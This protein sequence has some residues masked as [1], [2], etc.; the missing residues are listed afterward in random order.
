MFH[1]WF[2]CVSTSSGE[3]VLTE[4]PASL[5]GTPGQRVTIRC[6][7]GWGISSFLPWYQQKPDQAPKRLVKY[8]SQTVSGVPVRFSGSG[9]GTDFTLTIN[10]LEPEDFATYY[11]QQSKFAS[12]GVT[13]QH[14][15]PQGSRGGRLCCPS[16]APGSSMC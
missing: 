1:L 6:R 2:M 4:P 5:P 14:I 8:A 13:G 12:H 15:K 3:T 7:A 16:C 9:Y 10:G 11:C